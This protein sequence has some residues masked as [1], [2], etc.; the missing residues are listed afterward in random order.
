MCTLH[1][2]LLWWKCRKGATAH[3]LTYTLS[4]LVCY[5]GVAVF[6]VYVGFTATVEIVTRVEF[7]KKIGKTMHFETT[8]YR[9]GDLQDVICFLDDL[10][11]VFRKLPPVTTSMVLRSMGWEE[12]EGDRVRKS[13]RSSLH[14][15]KRSSSR[16]YYPPQDQTLNLHNS[17]QLRTT[18]KHSTTQSYSVM[19]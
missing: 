18:L 13:T 2:V 15:P 12:K 19:Q 14:R 9:T 10:L 11:V 16:Q 1:I 17:K 8:Q 7:R 5:L 4:L 3:I 6:S